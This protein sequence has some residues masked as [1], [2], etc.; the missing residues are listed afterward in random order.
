MH[1]G[2]VEAVIRR[3]CL[4]TMP[5]IQSKTFDAASLGRDVLG[6]SQN[7]DVR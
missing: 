2:S 6:S 4:M 7:S 3:I 1:P 5:E